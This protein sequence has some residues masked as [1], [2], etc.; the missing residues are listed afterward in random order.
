MTIK[1]QNTLVLFLA[2]IICIP[3]ILVGMRKG[4][5]II[6][7]VITMASTFISIILIGWSN[8]S[9]FHRNPSADNS[10]NVLN[11][12]GIITISIGTQ[13]MIVDNLLHIVIGAVVM[14]IG[15]FLTRLADRDKSETIE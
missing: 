6:E 1:T 14:I 15:A 3:M 5:D 10:S 2:M 11:V 8:K 4:W 13:I 7:Y 12:I 9:V